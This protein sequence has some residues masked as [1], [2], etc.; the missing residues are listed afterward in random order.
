MW[1]NLKQKRDRHFATLTGV[2]KSK[3]MCKKI[4]LV[5]LSVFVNDGKYWVFVG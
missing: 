1:K 4:V 5:E 2:L 3:K